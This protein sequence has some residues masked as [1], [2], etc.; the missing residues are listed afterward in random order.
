MKNYFHLLLFIILCLVSCKKE[1]YTPEGLT[2]MT[3]D[4]MVEM[5]TKGKN[6]PSEEVVYKDESGNKISFDS[7]K[8]IQNVA[9]EYTTD[10]Y[11]NKQNEIVEMVL[12]P[13]TE[14]DK[15]F[16]KRLKEAVKKPEKAVP[17]VIDCSRQKEI[18]EEVYVLD[19]GMRNNG[20]LNTAKDLENLSRVIS[21]I[22]Q[23]G[24]PPT[25]EVGPQQMMAI[26]LVFQHADKQYRKKYFP[27]L[28]AAAE[29]GD[30]KAS[31]IAM[32]QD[33]ILM[34]EGAPQIYG[35]QVGTDP[36]TGDYKLYELADPERVDSRRAEVGLGPLQEYLGRWNIAFTVEQVEE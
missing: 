2:K 17:V 36:G 29:K 31:H 27:L 22:E 9:E 18:L 10:M 14:E 15:A 4:Q 28:K 6:F 23:C 8:R 1:P 30:L 19:Q 32:M 16:K 12:R 21:L 3:E 35:T 20:N 34:D 13:A 26:W 11:L 25:E 24:M 33:R 7:I 5:F